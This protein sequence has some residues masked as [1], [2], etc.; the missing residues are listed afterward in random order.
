MTGRVF[1]VVPYG[2][3]F[4]GLLQLKAPVGTPPPLWGGSSVV[5]VWAGI[6][7]SLAGQGFEWAW[8]HFRDASGLV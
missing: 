8:N 2:G 6:W 7:A 1:G 4:Y 5:A 3:R